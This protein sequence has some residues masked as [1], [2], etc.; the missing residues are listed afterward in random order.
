MSYI[1]Y[2]V[3]PKYYI[4]IRNRVD[5][6]KY[7][8]SYNIFK[9]YERYMLLMQF[10]DQTVMSIVIIPLVMTFFSQILSKIEQVNFYRIF[11]IFSDFNYKSLFSKANC[12][13][14]KVE[15]IRN[16]CEYSG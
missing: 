12:V 9:N 5:D 7:K 4:Y 15:R 2:I 11:D 13:V 16:I 14:L 10:N 3:L 1:Y 8:S 6:K